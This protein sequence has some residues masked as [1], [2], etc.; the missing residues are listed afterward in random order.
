MAMMQPIN[1]LKWMFIINLALVCWMAPVF[2][3]A[4]VKGLGKT[5]P[6]AAEVLVFKKWVGATE[7][8]KA[9]KIQL[10]CQGLD[11]F[12]PLSINQDQPDGWLIA[13]IPAEG[14]YCSVMRQSGTVS[15]LTTVIVGIYWYSRAAVLNALWSI[16]N[17]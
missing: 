12:H 11:E 16:P 7:D 9:V 17:G 4:Q 2:S 13:D 15:Y 10:I 1:Y 8:E 3:Q 5:L 14:R 6:D